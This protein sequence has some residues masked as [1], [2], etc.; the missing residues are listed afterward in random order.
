M[1]YQ[2]TRPSPSLTGVVRHYWMLDNCLPQ[3]EEHVQRIVPNGLTELVFYHSTRPQISGP[4]APAMDSGMISGQMQHYYDLKVTGHLSL[5]AVTFQPQGL[6]RLLNIPVSELHNLSIPLRFLF[7]DFYTS[8]EDQIHDAITFKGRIQCVENFLMKRISES[9][10]KYN[11]ERINGSLRL[12]NQSKG[13][14]SIET[15]ASAACCSRRQYERIFTESIGTSPARFLR[16]VRFQWAIHARSRQP[17]STL[18]SLAYDCGFAD[19]SHMCN[20]F[21]RLSGMTPGQFFGECEPF[22]DYFQGIDH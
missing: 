19:Q 3:G 1:N 4:N 8:L 16:T 18:T 11:S 10:M 9:S 20:E 6:S 14:I 2:L 12:I 17:E 5:F 15:L 22:S 7:R 13:L 21:V